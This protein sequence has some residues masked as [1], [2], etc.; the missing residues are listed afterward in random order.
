MFCTIVSENVPFLTIPERISHRIRAYSSP[1]PSVFP[2]VS[3]HISCY[4]RIYFVLYSKRI[5]QR[6]QDTLSFHTQSILLAVIFECAF[7]HLPHRTRA[8]SSPCSSVFL[9]AP[10]RT[11]LTPEHISCYK[12][13]YFVLSS[14][15]VSQRTQGALSSHTQSILLA[16]IF[17]RAFC[18]LPH[19]TRAVLTHHTRV[20]FSLNSTAFCIVFVLH[21]KLYLNSYL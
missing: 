21:F 11:P 4:T 6:T 16:V 13:T 3:E 17:E 14:K 15:R 1:Y 18:H 7:Y 12:R 9:P 2:T 5:S 20:C 19:R 8:Y 10:E